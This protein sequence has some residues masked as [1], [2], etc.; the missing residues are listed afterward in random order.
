MSPFIQEAAI[1]A[2]DCEEDVQRMLYGY[3]KRRNMFMDGLNKISG[4]SVR[5][6]QGAFYAWVKFETF[7]EENIAT[8][9]L[10]KAHIVGVP[11]LAYGDGNEQFMRFSFANNE[12]E[13][14]EAIK[15]IESFMKMYI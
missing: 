2:L 8:H 7:N 11:G 12:E 9:L 6:P 4:I 3:E 14:A 5:A 1:T 15:R 13:L 10:E